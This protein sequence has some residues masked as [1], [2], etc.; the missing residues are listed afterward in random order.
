MPASPLLTALLAAL[1]IGLMDRIRTGVTTFPRCAAV[2]LIVFLFLLKAI[3]P[4]HAI[5]WKAAHS[6]DMGWSIYRSDLPKACRGADPGGSG[7][8]IDGHE[9]RADCI[10]CASNVRDGA[11]AIGVSPRESNPSP[12]VSSVVSI[13]GFHR[14][15]VALQTS[16]WMSSWASRA[17]PGA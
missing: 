17:P 14:E 8:P 9:G 12:V 7:P 10:C 15:V 1:S 2:C 4:A 16:G 6:S 5:G 3:A 13:A 11:I